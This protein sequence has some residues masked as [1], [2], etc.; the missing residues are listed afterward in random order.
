MKKKIAEGVRNIHELCSLRWMF[1]KGLP[2]V[3]WGIMGGELVLVQCNHYPPGLRQFFLSDLEAPPWWSLFILPAQ[4]SYCTIGCLVCLPSYLQL[5]W[6][7]EVHFVCLFHLVLSELAT[8]F[9]MPHLSKLNCTFFI[10]KLVEGGVNVTLDQC[11]SSCGCD[12][13]AGQAISLMGCDSFKNQGTFWVVMVSSVH[14][15]KL[16]Y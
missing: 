10:N 1:V 7:Q 6:S 13:L 5:T 15:W 3:S 2:Q 14:Y 8:W 4:E 11:F 16:L 12:L 9:C